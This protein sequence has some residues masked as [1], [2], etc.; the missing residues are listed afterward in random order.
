MTFIRT[1]STSVAALAVVAFSQGA[2][3]QQ[4]QVTSQSAAGFTGTAPLLYD[5]GNASGFNGAVSSSSIA[6]GTVGTISFTGGSGVFHGNQSGVVANPSG[7]A[8]NYLAAEPGGTV[9]LKLNSAQSSLGL[10]AGSVDSYNS[11]KFYLGG[12]LVGTLNGND[13]TANANGAQDPTGTYFVTVGG[14]AKGFDEVVFSST[15]P[16][17]EFS[18]YASNANPAP[19]PSFGTNPLSGLA[20]VA[21]MGG[22][23]MIR[24]R[25]A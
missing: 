3:A 18:L 14:F 19:L 10:L 25:T 2:Q 20:L 1:L 6:F 17:F 16:A 7:I 22:L 21:A 4:L 13:I 9:D 15:S 5:F 8:G 23:Y 12:Q 24:R 11:A